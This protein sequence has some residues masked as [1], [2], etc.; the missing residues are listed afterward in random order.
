MAPVPRA[1]SVNSLSTFATCMVPRLNKHG[2]L[3]LHR[4]GRGDP[5]IFVTEAIRKS[6]E[7]YLGKVKLDPVKYY[8]N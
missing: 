6:A 4:E 7:V 5:R 2:R 8:F 1:L 3:C